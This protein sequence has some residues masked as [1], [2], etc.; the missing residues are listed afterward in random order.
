MKLTFY[1]A[2]R[3]VTGSCTLVETKRARILVD[4][5]MFQ[6]S[7]V[8]D[9]KNYKEFD[10]DPSS[11]DAV[12]VTHAH[13]DHC[14]RLP[15]LLKEGFGGKIYMTSA[16][17]NIAG[18]VM[19]DAEHIMQEDFERKGRPKLYDEKDVQ[20]TLK[21]IQ[22][23]PY[24]KEIK[25]K[26]A[27]IRFFD[28]GHIF[29][30]SFIEIKE[31][32]GKTVVFSGDVGNKDVPIIR[33]TEAIQQADILVTES[34]Y[35][36]RFHE[37]KKERYRALTEAI[38]TTMNQN[39]VLLIPA[40]AIERTQHLLYEINHLV[41]SGKVKC[42]RVYLDSPMAIKVT[43]VMRKNPKYYD[44]EALRLISEGD[45]FLDF[46]CLTLTRTRDE[47]K[48]INTAP[49]PKVIIAGSGM[50]NGGRI[51]HHLIRYLGDKTTTLLIIGYQ[52][53]GTL[54]RRLYSGQKTVSIYGKRIRV[55]AKVKA[56]G[57]YSAHADQKKILSWIRGIPQKPQ[58]V[59]CNH[60]E[61]ESAVALCTA[62]TDK[63]GVDAKAPHYGESF[64]I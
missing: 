37:G 7:S 62:I 26:D 18:I 9:S 2:A 59:L 38:T 31:S 27:T 33:E 19:D 41:E 53:R 44:K 45:D 60:G 39:G 63:L 25:I 52:A 43:E 14:G 34:T 56:I 21:K 55:R 1:G 35:G 28:A 22:A 49:K 48:Q 12:C 30:S 6:G 16:T 8:A 61:E 40:F 36:N 15:K 23:T 58:L 5:G 13:L 32:G 4:C 46:S 54:G 57:A 20:K 51:L 29:G 50:M 3:E 24:H 47:S 17:K 11:V 64:E 42:Q 10:F